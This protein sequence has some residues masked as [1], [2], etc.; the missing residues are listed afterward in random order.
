MTYEVTLLELKDLGA[1]CNLDA[2]GA[3]TADAFPEL[4]PILNDYANRG[5]TGFESNDI[6]L[7]TQPNLWFP[8]A[9]SLIA[10]AIAYL[11]ENGKRVARQHPG[12]GQHG[13]VSV[14]A[15]GQDY[16]HLLKRR[17]EKLHGLLEEK[18]GHKIT[19]AYGVD[20]SPL[21]DRRVAERAGIGWVGKNSMFYAREYG[22]FVFIGTLA[23]DVDIEPAPVEQESRCGSCEQ[24]MIACPTKALIGP[25]MI[26]ATKCLSYITQMKGIIPKEFR[27][28]MGR[29]VWG[30]DTCQWSC[31]ENQHVHFSSHE[32]FLPMGELSYPDLIAILHWSNRQFLR[33]FGHSAAAWR[34]L[35]T[36][37]R[38]ALIALGNT[39]RIESIEEI[40]PF[41]THVRPE[42]RA[43]A[44]WACEKIGGL[45]A[46]AAV[47]TAW[48]EEQDE[49]V[50]AEMQW[51]TEGEVYF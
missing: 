13:Q 33:Q 50:R 42:L 25:G 28:P 35:P 21:V 43:S 36:W 1:T 34:G 14:Y 5:L 48:K 4:V 45:P 19:A 22:S 8:K 27:G 20:T 18:V 12:Q 30:C 23:V 26:D 2:I 44:A 17:L 15:Y 41:L 46:R 11:T 37:Q 39:K 49:R 6:A 24:C 47:R 10:V 29:R 40:I 7:R 32:E 38:N 9:K 51:A 3:T 31:P 16:H